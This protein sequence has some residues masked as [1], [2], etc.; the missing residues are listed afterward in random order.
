MRRATRAALMA[1]PPATGAQAMTRTTRAQRE[2]LH[3]V[4]KRQPLYHE[5]THPD[6]G[7]IR[8]TVPMTYRAFR[9]TMQGTFGCDGAVTVPWCGMW[10]C[11]ERDGYTHS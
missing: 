5:W 6:L 1:I 8:G 11:I 4:F 2:A 9:K 3:A 7:R 10:L